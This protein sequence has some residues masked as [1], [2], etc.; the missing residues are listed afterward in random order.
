MNFAME[1]THKT[2]H[3][4]YAW[5]F[6]HATALTTASTNDGYVFVHNQSDST[7]LANVAAWGNS[8][9]SKHAEKRCFK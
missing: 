4:M 8:G 6:P 7:N 5:T 2:V 3:H 9:G 1:I